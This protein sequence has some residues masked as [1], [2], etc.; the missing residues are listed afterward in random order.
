MEKREKL[1]MYI[2]VCVEGAAAAAKNFFFSLSLVGREKNFS[3]IS[4][5]C[6]C[7][8]LAFTII[9]IY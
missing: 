9:I 2:V 4:F 3:P 6:R 1:C 5:H 8:K 7:L